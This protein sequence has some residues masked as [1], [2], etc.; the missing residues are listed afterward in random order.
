MALGIEGGPCDGQ[1]IT[2]PV[3]GHG[4]P[5]GEQMLDS[6]RYVLRMHGMEPHPAADWHYCYVPAGR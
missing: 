5:P 1:E 4:R 2:V 6:A 3:Q